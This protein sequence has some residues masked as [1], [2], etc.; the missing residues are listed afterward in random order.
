ACDAVIA[1][2][3][4]AAELVETATGDTPPVIAVVRP[5]DVSLS[6]SLLAAGVDDVVTEPLD[7]LAVLLALRHVAMRPR[8][9]EAVEVAPALVG[10]GEAMTQLRAVIERIATH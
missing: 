4:L 10:D 6:L 1:D 2:G 5:R 3:A 8:K 9:A 7:E